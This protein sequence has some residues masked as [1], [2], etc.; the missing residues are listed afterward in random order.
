M[1]LDPD[2]VLVA[3]R[4]RPGRGA[5]LCASSPDCLEQAI[6]RRAFDRAFRRPVDP[7][8]AAGLRPALGE[9][10]AEMTTIDP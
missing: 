10:A 5:W 6:R 1:V 2:G 8:A 3:G 4:G 9:L 7:A